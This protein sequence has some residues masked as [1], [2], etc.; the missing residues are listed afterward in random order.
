MGRLENKVAF[1]TGAARG[2][3]REHCVR[4]A[5]EGADIIAVDACGPVSP[6]NAFSPA[7]PDDLAETTR[8]V[9]ATGRSIVARQVD[10][11]DLSALQAVCQDGAGE[12]GGI[13]IVVANAG[14][15]NWNRFWEMPEEQWQ[16]MIDINL[17]GVWKTMTAAAPIMVEQ[18]RGGSI[19]LTSSVA[20]LKSLPAQAH[21]SAAK[22]GLV[23]LCKTAA[24]E[25]GPYNIRVNTIHPWGVLT[26]M[27]EEDPTPFEMFAAHPSYAASFAAI[28]AEP[29][30]ANT[31]DIA[32]IVVFLASDES[33]VI[34]AAQIPADMGATKV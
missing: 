19:I 4:M 27:A 1:V 14:I 12:L 8:Q 18:G 30:I 24:I 6:H 7:T 25:L 34:T 13:D 16:T 22:H 15:S 20:G 23:G 26:K 17:T 31:R 11:R 9:E 2:Q 28:L 3:G 21:Y 33:R 32:N 10:V 5:E 29:Q